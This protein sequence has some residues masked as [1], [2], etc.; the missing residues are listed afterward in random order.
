MIL[1]DI[2][3]YLIENCTCSGVKNKWGDGAE[4]KL[5]SGYQSEFMNS[6]WCNAETTKCE[7]AISLEYNEWFYP[8]E[9]RFGPSQSACS[10]Y[11][12][13]RMSKICCI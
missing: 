10:K 13:S 3:H 6:I 11:H 8:E 7:D 12:G 2:K 9:G 4:C 1:I 5:Y